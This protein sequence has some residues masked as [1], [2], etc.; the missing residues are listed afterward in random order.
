MNSTFKRNATF[1][2]IINLKNEK[3]EY[4]ITV[5]VPLLITFSELRMYFE[6]TLNEMKYINVYNPF[7][8]I[9]ISDFF[10]TK[11][12]VSEILCASLKYSGNKTEY[13]T[14]HVNKFI[15]NK[16]LTTES[17]LL[18]YSLLKINLEQSKLYIVNK[19]K[20]KEYSYKDYIQLNN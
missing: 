2:D 3:N 6:Y 8:L 9:N 12:N 11:K 5:D 18:N 14:S 10:E 4:I 16:E 17:I 20:I 1:N 13:L 15:R 7:D 19:N